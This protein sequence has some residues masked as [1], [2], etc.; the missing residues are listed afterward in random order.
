L[1]LC[2]HLYRRG[3]MYWWR[4]RL[5]CPDGTTI[6]AL[7]L[8]EREPSRAISL[9]IAMT[10]ASEDVMQLYPIG[11]ARQQLQAH[12][13]SLHLATRQRV[14][15]DRLAVLAA[16]AR[17][18][19]KADHLLRERR[20]QARIYA[21]LNRIAAEEGDVVEDPSAAIC[22]H[23]LS[24]LTEFEIDK[25][26]HR[27]ERGYAREA[28]RPGS[29]V[30]NVPDLTLIDAA[31][32]EEWPHNEGDVRFICKELAKRR[33]EI[34]S[35]AEKLYT[36]ALN[37]PEEPVAKGQ[38]RLSFDD[39]DAAWARP[40]H[41][42]AD[43]IAVDAFVFVKT[44]KDGAVLPGHV[45]RHVAAD[46]PAANAQPS[47]QTIAAAPAQNG[48]A[49]GRPPFEAELAISNMVDDLIATSEWGEKTKAQVRSVVHLFQRM[50]ACTTTRALTE[51][52]FLRYRTLLNKIPRTYGK[53]P[54]DFE[55]SLDV[56]IQ[57][58]KQNGKPMGLNKQTINRHITQIGA[59]YAFGASLKLCGDW[60]EL[61]K[62]RRPVVKKK[63]KLK[64][65]RFEDA[66]ATLI[67]GQK[68]W[69]QRA[70]LPE[71][72]LY[73][74]VLLAAFTGARQAE[75]A[76][77]KLADIDTD[78]E[79]IHIRR[80][81][82]RDVKTEAGERSIPIHSELLRLAFLRYVRAVQARVGMDADLF[83]DLRARGSRTSHGVLLGKS[84]AKIM[85]SSGLKKKKPG[86]SFHSWRHAANTKMA[87]VSD[88]IRE[89]I[90]GHEGETI[91]TSV[92]MHEIE[93][94]TIKQAIELVKWDT[95]NLVPLRWN[96]WVPPSPATPRSPRS[97]R[98]AQIGLTA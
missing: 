77:L 69:L 22:K 85:H 58:A 67:S 95:A 47:P 71:A 6:V 53:S 35:E 15:D 82:N 49:A 48:G 39:C 38:A 30:A 34:E 74:G 96:S 83:P 41:Q 28:Y 43:L 5:V 20:S 46:R 51:H 12:L 62:S 59:I 88:A 79:I 86:L 56:V 17:G 29:S 84:F 55:G 90:L 72:S 61:I 66:E 19:H 81:A 63:D 42:T 2:S 25:I 57:N 75:I 78:A 24:D 31:V 8:N 11:S 14:E 94:M 92:Y 89:Q 10:A 32:I 97:K 16:R 80:N 93:R 36:R 21:T 18:D 7:S 54:R 68:E 1:P 87:S 45:K 33:A 4:R 73:W 70:V 44:D 91:N 60:S 65:V 76:G 64:K 98:P 52:N 26:L 37:K 13:A 9:A 3:A 23:G 50:A 27:L 40:A